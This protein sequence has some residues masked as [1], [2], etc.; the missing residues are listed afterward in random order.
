VKFLGGDARLQS[1]YLEYVEADALSSQ[2]GPDFSFNGSRTDALKV[3]RDVASALAKVHAEGF[4]HADVKPSNVLYS[5]TRG[6]VL[7][8]FGLSFRHGNPY[9]SGGTPWYMSPEFMEDIELR[10]VASDIWALGVTALFLLGYIRLPDKTWEVWQISDIHPTQRPT[11]SHQTAM[12]KMFKCLR[13]VDNA[14]QK[15]DQDDELESI[16]S[17]T[18]EEDVKNRIDAVSLCEQLDRLQLAGS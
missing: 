1:L 13:D 3:M 10:G 15:L 17:K 14:R 8:D 11:T 18:L 7:I 12:G 2:V 6:A 16:V 9:S 4:V 5:P